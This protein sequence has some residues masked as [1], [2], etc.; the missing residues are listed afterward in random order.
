MNVTDRG[1]YTTTYLDN[2]NKQR[3]H[4]HRHPNSR[5]RR[6]EPRDLNRKISEYSLSNQT[7]KN[8]TVL[9]GTAESP[10]FDHGTLQ[11]TPQTNY[12]AS[13]NNDTVDTQN[14]AFDPDHLSEEITP[15]QLNIL[16]KRYQSHKRP[17]PHRSRRRRSYYDEPDGYDYEPSGHDYDDYDYDYEYDEASTLNESNKDNKSS[18]YD[19]YYNRERNLRIPKSNPHDPTSKGK[20]KSKSNIKSRGRIRGNDYYIQ[21]K[22]RY[23]EAEFYKPTNYTHKTFRDVFDDNDEDTGK[24]NPMEYVF[25]DP[26]K[27]KEQEQNQKLKTAFKNFQVKLGRDDY[28][29]YDYYDNKDRKSNVANEIFVTGGGESDDDSDYGGQQPHDIVNGDDMAGEGGGDMAGGSGDKRPKKK[30]NFKKMWKTKTKQFKKDLGKDF[31]KN[32]EKQWVFE[33]EKKK[34][35][36]FEQQQKQLE[37]SEQLTHLNDSEYNPDM[38]DTT[39]GEPI[40]IEPDDEE[41]NKFYAGPRP[42]FHPAWN[43][44]LSWLA[45]DQPKSPSNHDHNSHN[46]SPI[47]IADET[48][49]YS[50]MPQSESKTLVKSAKPPLKK[51]KKNNNDNIKRIKMTKEQLKN[52]NKNVSKVKNMWNLPASNLFAN[53]MAQNIANQ[54]SGKLTYQHSYFNENGTINESLPQSVDDIDLSPFDGNSQEFVIEVDDEDDAEYDE[55]LYYNPNTGQ[56]EREP[57]TSYSAMDGNNKSL[58]QFSSSPGSPN[59]FNTTGKKSLLDTTSGPR[60]IISNINKLIKSVKI[61]RIVFAPID[62]IAESFPSLQTFVILLELGIFMWLLY[63]LSLLIDALCM[64][65]KAVCAPMI[66][67]GRFMNR[68]V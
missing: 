15:A 9:N 53:N 25:D 34:Q 14:I 28:D 55:E 20:P 19:K 33:E 1:Y 66:A 30:V 45:Y 31:F 27:I 57:P 3:H 58:Q 39:T 11:N 32:M 41:S 61:M 7:E 47:Q 49:D 65:V 62:I 10:S 46:Q 51:N 48:I 37:E 21:Q 16:Q 35:K 13:T 40:V 18:L 6:E 67:M 2:Y 68:I 23:D 43:Y 59:T 4:H 52:F 26:E 22:K 38:T 12:T 29:N 5:R 54:R 64:M 42:D 24:Y 8:S 17:G 50:S 63:E 56:L 60:A 44:L 36:E